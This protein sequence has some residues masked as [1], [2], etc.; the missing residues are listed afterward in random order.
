MG[1][2]GLKNI[3]ESVVRLYNTVIDVIVKH[4]AKWVIFCKMCLS[5]MSVRMYRNPGRACSV[6]R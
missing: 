3:F 1:G 5:E 4:R 2:N 6:M